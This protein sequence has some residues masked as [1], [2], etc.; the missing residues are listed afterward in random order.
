ML[1]HCVICCTVG[2]KIRKSFDDSGE[3]VVPWLKN[4]QRFPYVALTVY[5]GAKTILWITHAWTRRNREYLV[6][7]GGRQ[8]KRLLGL[9]R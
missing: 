9:H 3:P 8:T 5:V 6:I 4:H 7:L 2:R 1:C